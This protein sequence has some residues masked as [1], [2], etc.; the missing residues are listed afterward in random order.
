[1]KYTA[2]ER[3]SSGGTSGVALRVHWVSVLIFLMAVA[4]IGKVILSY[5][6]TKTVSA[7]YTVAPNTQILA[8]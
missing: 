8:P 5:D 6:E 7:V 3:A 2:H 1:M 4:L